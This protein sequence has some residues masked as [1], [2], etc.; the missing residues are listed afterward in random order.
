[1]A[2]LTGMRNRLVLGVFIALLAAVWSVI[3]LLAGRSTVDM[4]V[5]A[6]L[7]AIAGLGVAFLL[8]QCGMVSLAQNVFFGIGAYS[9]AYGATVLGWPAP[10]SIIM[11]VVISGAIA[12]AVGVP[13]LRLSGYFLALATLALAVIG[14]VL[15]LEWDWLTGGTLGIGGI[16]PLSPLG[17]RINTPVRFYYFVSPILLVLI[18]YNLLHSRT[19]IAMRAM[20]DAPSAAAVLGVNIARLKVKVFVSS[21]ILGSF[22]GSLFAHYVSF[23]SVDSFGVDRAINFLLIAV[24]GGARTIAGTVLGA[25]FVTALPNFLSR[26][27]DV[28]ALLF[29][30]LLIVAV[31][32]LPQGFG[33]AVAQVWRH[34]GRRPDHAGRVTKGSPP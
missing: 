6:A 24:L 4:L 2:S 32:F 13:V 15:F 3:P 17:Y 11:G 12:A 28:H 9:T 31:I 29:A 33:G 8:G 34:F 20:R 7:Y 30:I 21:A 23:V 10:A 14:H 26:I 16:P 25:L 22:A 19:G 5:F 1:M 27:G 18:L